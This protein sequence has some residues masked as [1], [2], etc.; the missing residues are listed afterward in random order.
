MEKTLSNLKKMKKKLI[1]LLI[2]SPIIFG[3][4]ACGSKSDDKENIR[5]IQIGGTY[6]IPGG[7]P[8]LR[9]YHKIQFKTS[10]RYWIFREPL[11]CSG[12]GNW[13]QTGNIINLGPNDSDCD[14][15]RNI[16]KKYTF[17]DNKLQHL[18]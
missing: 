2:V 16:P 3:M 1:V 17:K 15:T 4:N 12:E 7:D 6:D 13:S 8:V 10:S 9:V 5:Q 14:F 11:S 18:D